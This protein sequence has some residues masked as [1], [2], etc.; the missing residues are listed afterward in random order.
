LVWGGELLIDSTEVEANAA[1]ASLHPRFAVE[2]HL[3]R[4]FPADA[5][6]DLE[7]PGDPGEAGAQTC[8]EAHAP[9]PLP[10]TRTHEARAELAARAAERHDWFAQLGRPDPM[11]PAGAVRRT[12]DYRISTTD[13]DATPLRPNRAHGHL[14]Y[15]DHYVV[16]GGTARII[17][18]TLVTPA[19]VSDNQP[20]VALLW[21][22]RFRWK[23]HPD[24]IIGDAKYGTVENIVAIE[25]QGMRAMLPL[26]AAGTSP[27]RFRETDF[28]YDPVTDT[29][30]C[31]GA[32]TLRF[33]AITADTEHRIYG[34]RPK[35]CAVCPLRGQ[36][37]SSR[38]GRKI[39]RS[40]Y[41]AYL[42][43][44]RGYHETPAYAKAMRKRRVWV[45]P[46]FAEAKQWHGLR[47][48][49]ARTLAQVTC[50][51]L[52]IAAGQ[53]LKRL[54]SIRGWGR[55]PWPS[56]APGLRLPA[57]PSRAFGSP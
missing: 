41:A 42:D 39:R 56:G 5:G 44:V 52:L 55:R 30:R 48:F 53:N 27:G 35:T 7:D 29:Y 4:L 50:E 32:H 57:A 26:S 22:T 10:I 18:T 51:A 34:A 21:Q 19:S 3:A 40:P 43:R 49:R 47:R 45:E 23:L 11:I 15:H 54:V 13:P 16:D 12:A 28:V 2:A 8:D 38:Y 31:P 37:T 24:Q 1:L 9:I 20:A 33:Q 25:D 17:L 6:D 36:C 14:G 46:L